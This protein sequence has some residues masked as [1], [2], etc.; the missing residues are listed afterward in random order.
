MSSTALRRRAAPWPS[1][2]AGT[3]TLPVRRLA[4]P[5]SL[6]DGMFDEAL[7]SAVTQIGDRLQS[8][9]STRLPV[10]LH[11]AMPAVTAELSAQL[12]GLIDG[13]TPKIEEVA[14]RAFGE[15]VRGDDWQAQVDELQT[16]VAQAKIQF[17]IGIALAAIGSSV[18]TY[19]LLRPKK[20]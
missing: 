13:I 1:A 12:P 4:E 18:L 2:P 16:E 10:I 14:Q 5:S 6:G 9:I 8:E 11:D 7:D 20:S 17:G 19:F 15:I 3:R